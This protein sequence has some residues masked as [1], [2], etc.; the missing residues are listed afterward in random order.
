M[1]ST[2]ANRPRSATRR[3]GDDS[4]NSTMNSAR[5]SYDIDDFVKHG[6]MRK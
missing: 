6:M 1:T 3:R 4:L 2:A 5:G